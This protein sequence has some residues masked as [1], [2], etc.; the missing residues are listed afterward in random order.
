MSISP[1]DCYLGAVSATHIAGAK[2]GRVK[3][4][5]VIVATFFL[6]G[7]AGVSSQTPTPPS[8]A[9][10]AEPVL[11]SISLSPAT[12]SIHVG[13]DQTFLAQGLDQYNH[14]MTGV[15]FAWVSS[16]DGANGNAIA[17]FHGG[18]A[19]GVSAGVMHVVAS[20]SGV[21]S[22]P[23]VLT[24]ITPPTTLAGAGHHNGRG[25]LHQVDGNS[26]GGM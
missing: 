18:V 13:E 22:A 19:R 2:Q 9:I 6:L 3:L 26:P 17:M 14:P 10:S 11:T 8:A 1:D 23:A 7:C 16:D 5:S 15:I 4:V 25:N 24:V 20:A 12:A 21:T